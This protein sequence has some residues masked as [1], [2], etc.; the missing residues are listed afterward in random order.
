MY[1]ESDYTFNKQT[2]IGGDSCDAS[3]RS[4]QDTNASNYMLTNFQPNCP[5]NNVIDFA[6][7]QPAI[8]FTGSHKG[9]IGGCNIDES[10][11]LTITGL[12]RN[13]DKISLLERPYLTVPYLG[14]GKSNAMMESQIQQSEIANNRKSVN[15]SS[16]VSHLTYR[17]TPLISSIKSTITNPANLIESD[18]ANGWIRGGIPV[19][20]M[21]RDME[22]VNKQNM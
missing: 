21:T 8:N 3:Q 17:Q 6:T 2:R 19:R 9:G 4:I 20:Q 22:H 15:P 18:A 5:L 7:S 11:V 1:Y 13:K 10:S 14:R 12:T 16:E